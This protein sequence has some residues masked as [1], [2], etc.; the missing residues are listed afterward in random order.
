MPKSA[1]SANSQAKAC[2]FA[3]AAALIG[4][5]R[6][7][8]HLFNSCYTF[9]AP[10]DAFSNAVS[11]Q[12]DAGKIKVVNF[13]VSKVGESVETRRRTAHEAVDWYAA[14]ARDTFG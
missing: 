2:A 10:H 5:P 12:P 8:P 13:F 9:L 1:F 11:F 14:L 7:P 6:F 3:I 4:S